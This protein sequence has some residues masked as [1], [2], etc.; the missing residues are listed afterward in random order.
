MYSGN[1][2]PCHPLDSLVSAAELLAS[3]PD[4]SFCFVGGGTEWHRLRRSTSKIVFL[5]YQPLD[6]LSAMLSAADL[7][8]MVM[9]DPFVGLVHP[10][11]LYNLIRI[12]VPLLYIGP[13]KSHVTDLLGGSPRNHLRLLTARHGE[14]QK[15][16]RQIRDLRAKSAASGRAAPFRNGFSQAGLVG[17]LVAELES[18]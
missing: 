17:R 11:K 12:G 1:H 15:I 14:V 3:E 9:G 8:V 6:R 18:L 5:P 16:A 4:I 13:P 10:C 7:H 2:S